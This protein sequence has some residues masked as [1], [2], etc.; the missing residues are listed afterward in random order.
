MTHHQGADQRTDQRQLDRA[1]AS[2]MSPAERAT[3]EV[4]F[5]KIVGP[6]IDAKLEAKARE[7]LERWGEQQQRLWSA[8]GFTD[9][10]RDKLLVSREE[11][12]NLLG[13]S[14]ST[15]KRMED[16][17]E[18]PAPQRFGERIVRHRLVDIE[19]VAKVKLAVWPE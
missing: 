3:F 15:I 14:L 2:L 13:V 18:L 10:D 12:A 11:A 1:K 5:G 7:L 4:Q 19:A 9:K 17:G 8:L 16:S 6:L